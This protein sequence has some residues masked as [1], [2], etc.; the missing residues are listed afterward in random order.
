MA[1][2]ALARAIAAGKVPVTAYEMAVKAGYT[3]TEEQFAQDMGNS[4]TNAAN[5]AASASA[6]AASAE[7]VSASA[8]QIATNTNDISDLKE[9]LN[10]LYDTGEALWFGETVSGTRYKTYN[11]NL[12]AG[13]YH[14]T[15]DGIT[16]SDMDS[17]TCLFII[18]TSNPTTNYITEQLERNTSIGIDFSL[19]VDCDVIAFYASNKNTNSSGDT[20]EFSNVKITSV[21]TDDTLTVSGKPADAKATGDAFAN[22]DDNVLSLVK[23]GFG[24]LSYPSTNAYI[25]ANGTYAPNNS[26]KTT[27]PIAIKNGQTVKYRLSHGNNLPVISY[28]SG[29]DSGF[30]SSKSVNGIDGYVVGTYTATADGY[31]RFTYHVN[32][33]DVFAIFNEEIAD[34]VKARTQYNKDA[35]E[36]IYTSGR[37]LAIDKQIFAGVRYINIDTDLP[38]GVC[39]FDCS[40]IVSDDTDSTTCFVDFRYIDPADS[41]SNT[42]VGYFQAARNVAVHETLT[43]TGRCNRIVLYA[44]NTNTH[45][46]G[47]AVTFNDVTVTCDITDKTLSI[48]GKYADAKATGDAIGLVNLK[49]KNI[50]CLGDSIFGNDGQIVEYINEFTE[51]TAKNC[52]FGGT[53]VLDR[54]TTDWRYFDGEKLVSALCTQTWT[55]QDAAAQNLASSYPWISARLAAIK[56][57]DMSTIDIITMDWGTNDYTGDYAG[58]DGESIEEITTAYNN[59]IDLLQATFP[60]IR[61]LI[62]CPIWRYF[63]E[64]TDNK[65]GDN[66]SEYEG[67][68]TLKEVASAIER[69]AKDKRIEVIQMYQKMPLCYNT[70]DSYFDANDSTH[71]NAVGNAVY[72]HILCGKLRSMY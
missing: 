53:R 43:L 50:L 31:I 71:L 27:N 13:D 51:A 5:A 11:V 46:I 48:T 21:I 38:A 68:P 36:Q 12:K 35:I 6:A 29:I 61:L 66:W 70:A 19:S 64:K 1:V 32:K 54:G 3:G 37:M 67:G 55:D 16:S 33:T 69:F 65:N 59:V 62:I 30:D 20:F 14:L 34:N 9:S 15:C 56:A 23:N 47:D 58:R 28:F 25:Q 60:T 63:G 40:S 4:G 45:S 2:D 22:I 72:A 10:E 7:S 41:S 57:V 17:T 52:A 49:G 26:Y 8:A 18:G 39:V 42:E 24:V 44:S